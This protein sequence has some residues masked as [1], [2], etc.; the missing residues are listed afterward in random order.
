MILGYVELGTVLLCGHTRADK[1]GDVGSRSL[2]VLVR[3]V[4]LGAYFG[5]ELYP[6]L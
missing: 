4:I 6:C 2:A 3:A 1:V 5:P